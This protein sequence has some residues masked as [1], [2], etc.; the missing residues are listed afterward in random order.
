MSFGN[1]AKPAGVFDAP[2]ASFA[3]SVIQRIAPALT[4]SR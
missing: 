4:T 2:S 3:A 1:R